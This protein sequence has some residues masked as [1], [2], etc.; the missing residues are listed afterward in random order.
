MCIQYPYMVTVVGAGQGADVATS[1][2]V[3]TYRLCKEY[4]N[5]A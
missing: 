4:I 2:L 3:G 1:R 5:G